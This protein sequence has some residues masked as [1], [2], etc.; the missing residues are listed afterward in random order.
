MIEQERITDYWSSVRD[1]IDKVCID[2]DATWQKRNRVLNSKIII[3]MIFKIILSDR[4]QGLTINLTE[5]WERCAEKDIDLPQ[6][7]S[8][9]AS[10][11]CEARQKVSEDIFKQLNKDVLKNWNK[12]RSL[13][14]WRGHRVYA[15]DG[16]RINIPRELVNFGF[17]IYDEERRHYPQGF[18]LA[19]I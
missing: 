12:E 9:T 6:T 2:Y 3:L 19:T 15:T 16:S 18:D 5:F 8:V 13:P 4:N 14:L 1:I 11:F 17:K 7:K 10:S